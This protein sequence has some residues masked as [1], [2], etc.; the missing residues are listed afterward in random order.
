VDCVSIAESRGDWDVVECDCPRVN[1]EVNNRSVSAVLPVGKRAYQ[2]VMCVRDV[3]GTGNKA[4][5]S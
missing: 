5:C 3:S 4:L 2:S 1:E